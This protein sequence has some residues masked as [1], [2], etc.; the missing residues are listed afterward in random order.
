MDSAKFFQPNII[1]WGLIFFIYL[2]LFFL[3]PKSVFWSPDEG[4]KLIQ[5][6]TLGWDQGLHYQIPYPGYELDPSYQFYPH[7][8]PPDHEFYSVSLLYPTPYLLPLNLEP[9]T[10]CFYRLPL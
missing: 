3:T 7:R 6:Q 10:V 8:Q 2:G 1:V 4:A 9:S 5:L